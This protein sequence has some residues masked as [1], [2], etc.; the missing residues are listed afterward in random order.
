VYFTVKTDNENISIFI[1]FVQKILKYRVKTT[2][3]K[4]KEDF[5]FYTLYVIT[6]E[7]HCLLFMPPQ[8]T[9]SGGNIFSPIVPLAVPCQL[10]ERIKTRQF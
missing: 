8:A 4:S 3:R 9:C 1:Y 7:L 6:F 5:F 2:F 10:T